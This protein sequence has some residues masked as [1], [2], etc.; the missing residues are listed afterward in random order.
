[1]IPFSGLLMVVGVVASVV[2]ALAYHV[3]YGHGW[4]DAELEADEEFAMMRREEV[5]DERE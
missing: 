5:A 1:M 4:T 2:A 3:G